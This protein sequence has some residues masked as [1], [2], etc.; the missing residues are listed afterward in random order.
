MAA[1]LGHKLSGKIPYSQLHSSRLGAAPQFHPVCRP[2]LEWPDSTGEAVGP[3]RSE[4]K[5]T[6]TAAGARVCLATTGTKASG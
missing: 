5:L 4:Y 1:Q 6:F 2:R 3:G